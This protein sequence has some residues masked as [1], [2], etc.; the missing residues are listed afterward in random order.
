M[1]FRGSVSEAAVTCRSG[2]A[3]V[4]G[5]SSPEPVLRPLFCG[6]VTARPRHVA[7]DDSSLDPRTGGT[8]PSATLA[9]PNCT[10]QSSRRRRCQRP[11]GKLAQERSQRGRPTPELRRQRHPVRNDVVPGPGE[12]GWIVLPQA[13]CM[14]AGPLQRAIAAKQG[15]AVDPGASWASRGWQ[16]GRVAAPPPPA[17]RYGRSPVALFGA[18]RSATSPPTTMCVTAQ[19]RGQGTDR[20]CAMNQSQEPDFDR[21]PRAVGLMVQGHPLRAVGDV[22]SAP[23]SWRFCETP[24]SVGS[25]RSSGCRS[26]QRTRRT[27]GRCRPRW[28]ARALVDIAQRSVSRPADATDHAARWFGSTRSCSLLLNAQ[29][30]QPRGSGPGRS[31]SVTWPHPSVTRRSLRTFSA[32]SVTPA[33]CG[34]SMGAFGSC[35][36]CRDDVQCD[37]EMTS[38]AAVS[39]RSAHPGHGRGAPRRLIA[40]AARHALIPHQQANRLAIEEVQP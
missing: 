23:P 35:E 5:R 16:G 15:L 29:H 14:L 13:L 1:G 33:R 40:R 2:L 3:G 25:S 37:R 32:L 4:A 17:E 12:F 19:R 36:S 28:S 11:K 39:R 7:T 31:S 10:P 21:A 22:G 8:D 24:S 20:L 27:P 38:R 9:A 30:P 34:H 6:R 18:V 26:A